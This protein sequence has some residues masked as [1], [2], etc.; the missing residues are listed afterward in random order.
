VL[1]LF[2]FSWPPKNNGHKKSFFE[3]PSIRQTVV[4][5]VVLG[6]VDGKL[7]WYSVYRIPPH[8]VTRTHAATP[9][10]QP[11]RPSHDRLIYT[12]REW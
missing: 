6:G 2:Y 9:R 11:S 7:L 10:R 1:L 12:Q 8:T 3:E 5:L 4:F